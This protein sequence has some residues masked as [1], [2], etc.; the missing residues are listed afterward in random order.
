[1]RKARHRLTP[2]EER[3]LQIGVSLYLATNTEGKWKLRVRENSPG[4]RVMVAFLKRM[5]TSKQREQVLLSCLANLP[6]I[7]DDDI[8]VTPQFTIKLA[9]VWQ[10]GK[11][12]P[13]TGI[14]FYLLRNWDG[15]DGVDGE[16]VVVLPLKRWTDECVAQLLNSIASDSDLAAYRR[17][18]HGELTVDTYR[19][20]RTGLDLHPEQPPLVRQFEVDGTV[21]KLR[22]KKPTPKI[23]RKLLRQ[24]GRN[25]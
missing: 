21:I 6:K 25:L 5:K 13:F 15:W 8:Q 14:E 1:M 11:P 18:K 10:D 4:H 9:R 22:Q 12:L 17:G 16:N 23:D 20:I 24:A 2:F 3:V 7:P 19:K